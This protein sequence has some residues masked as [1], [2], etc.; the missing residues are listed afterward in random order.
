MRR[1]ITAA[2]VLAI[3]AAIAGPAAAKSRSVC[4]RVPRR[5]HVTCYALVQVHKRARRRH[6]GGDVI[7]S[8]VNPGGYHPADLQTA[9]GLASTAA[10]AGI[11]QTVAIVDAYG[12]PNAASNLATYRSTFGLPACGSGCFTQV[13]QTGGANLPAAD[14]GW[15]DEISLDL[16]MVSAVCPNCKILL[17]EAS[18]TSFSNLLT[19]E[20][21]A[22]AHATEVSNSW[23]SPEFSG[24]N[25]YDSYFEK[26]IPITFASGDSGYGV[27]YPA[28][29]PYVTAVGGTTLSRS[30]DARGFSETAWSGSGSGC[31]AYE[32]KPSWQ[33]EAGCTKRAIADV[34]A[35]ANPST[36]VAVFDTYGASGWL[37]FG[38]T[39]VAAP[40]IAGVYA[41]AGG[42]KSALYGSLPY[43]HTGSMFDVVGGST[44][45]CSVTALCTAVSGYDGPTG[46]GSPDGITA[47]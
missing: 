42:F 26:S 24:E 8:V 23:G 34:S 18:S 31:S 40:I 39:S 16:D 36:G 9:Y 19:A 25:T 44:G 21:Y 6:G 22:T 37:Q 15:S 17:V 41:L 1:L 12:D 14:S 32:P 30:S 27:Q 33:K 35:D 13:N 28:A 38:G 43:A 2:S 46:L 11:G 5:G 20:N 4:P 45:K 47:F 3:F 29:S 7:A 10:K